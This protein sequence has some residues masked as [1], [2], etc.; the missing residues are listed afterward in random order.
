MAPAKKVKAVKVG[1][2]RRRITREMLTP[3]D[4]TKFAKPPGWVAPGE[5][6]PNG[7][8]AVLEG[9]Q[10]AATKADGADAGYTMHCGGTTEYN[11]AKYPE[12]EFPR[13]L[14]FIGYLPTGQYFSKYEPDSMKVVQGEHLSLRVRE[15][16]VAKK[17]K[18]G[19]KP[20]RRSKRVKQPPRRSDRLKQPPV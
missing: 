9:C 6:I 20:Q 2:F 18:G 15:K 14:Q 5:V 12:E 7:G 1:G 17:R 19:G 11:R 8:K 10:L 4:Y 3:I 16:I 13:M